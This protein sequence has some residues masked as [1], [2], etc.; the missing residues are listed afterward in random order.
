VHES[1]PETASLPWNA[2]STG[3][4]YQPFASAA[5]AGAADRFGA[6][7]SYSN[8]RVLAAETLPALSVHVPLADA[9]LESGPE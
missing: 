7:A 2:T 3:W 9:E 8:E 5:R 6:V 1:T 4:L